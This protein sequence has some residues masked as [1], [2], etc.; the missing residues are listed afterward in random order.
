TDK[1]IIEGGD[2][3]RLKVI[4]VVEDYHYQSLQRTI[5]PLVHYYV[6]GHLGRM[7]VR[8]KP[9]R[10]EDGLTLLRDKWSTLDA[11]EAINYRF[12]D[13]TNDNLYKEQVRL[14]ATCSLFSMI[15]VVISAI[16]LVTI[17]TYSIRLRRKEVSIRK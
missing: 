8:L 1:E 3:Q 12:F 5:Q 9:G 17:P 11:F 16:G 14:T 15:A 4:G 10:I 13:D 7:A 2:G 6:D